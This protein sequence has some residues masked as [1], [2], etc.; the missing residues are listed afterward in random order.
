MLA[1]MGLC[2]SVWFIVKSI[3]SLLVDF[4]TSCLVIFVTTLRCHNRLTLPFLDLVA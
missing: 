2:P 1:W 4:N 3:A